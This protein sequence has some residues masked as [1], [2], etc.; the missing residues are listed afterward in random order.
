[1]AVLRDFAAS[2]G[3]SLEESCSTL[4]HYSPCAYTDRGG[5]GQTLTSA[6]PQELP[7]HLR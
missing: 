1:M 3:H 6:G 2:P 7:S 5:E 4:T